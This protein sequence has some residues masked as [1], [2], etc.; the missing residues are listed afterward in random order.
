MVEMRMIT[1]PV[2]RF[3]IDIPEE[4][5]ISWG[6]QGYEEPGSFIQT[7]E[8]P[9]PNLVKEAMEYDAKKY[10]KPHIDGGSQLESI[11]D[12]HIP[13]CWFMFFWDSELVK[14][15]Y[16]EVK[17]YFWKGGQG[18]VFRNNAV[19]TPQGMR[20]RADLLERYFLMVQMRSPQEIPTEP[21]FCFKNAYFQGGPKPDPTENIAMHVNLPSHPDVC[22][23]FCTD[24]EYSA[25]QTNPKLLDRTALTLA[26]D[27]VNRLS[28]IRRLRA[29]DRTVGPYHGQELL[30]RIREYNG[31]VGYSFMWECLGRPKSATHPNLMLEMMTGYGEPPVASSLNRKEAMA[32]WD[33]MVDS[34]RYRIPE[35]P[36]PAMS[37][38]K[39]PTP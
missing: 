23:R 22:V 25:S 3:L 14:D 17:G 26:E 15:N 11:V 35:P 4:A 18:F 33:A 19:F 16:I 6:R 34:I 39:A 8:A 2:G 21:G 27:A 29:R 32:L 10:R 28:G 5:T 7:F 20:E 30:E 38:P 37:P 13:N 24:V 12:G 36:P 9:T 1:V 31:T